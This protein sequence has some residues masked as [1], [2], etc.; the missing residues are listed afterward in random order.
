MALAARW[1]NLDEPEQARNP[2]QNDIN[3]A[4]DARHAT[5]VLQLQ[6]AYMAWIRPRGVTVSTL[7]SESSDRGSN[8]REASWKVMWS[9][10]KLVLENYSV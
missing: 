2:Q 4:K 3:P 10:V 9:F 1:Y 5:L 8:P 6:C 7:D